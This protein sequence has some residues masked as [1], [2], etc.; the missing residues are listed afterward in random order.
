MDSELETP[1]LHE[2]VKRVKVEGSGASRT[3]PSEVVPAHYGCS[4]RAVAHTLTRRANREVNRRGRKGR[5]S[6]SST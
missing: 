3:E 6:V 2:R 1:T 4:L 5:P